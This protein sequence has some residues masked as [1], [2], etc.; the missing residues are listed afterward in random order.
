MCLT[1]TEYCGIIISINFKE[2]FMDI[3]RMIRKATSSIAFIGITA[4]LGLNLLLDVLY[5]IDFFGGHIEFAAFIPYMLGFVADVCLLV[6]AL[7][8]HGTKGIKLSAYAYFIIGIL[9]AIISVINQKM[10]SFKAG[11]VAVSA[12]VMVVMLVAIACIFFKIRGLPVLALGGIA[13]VSNVISVV[14]T[15]SQ[16]G[17]FFG[18]VPF[19]ALVI[20]IFT[21]PIACYLV[22][23][24]K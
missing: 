11:G 14:Q 5:V 12:I 2:Y 23:T 20:P 22:A 4:I 24:D 9:S 19:L 13:L 7:N 17:A 3:S 21:F 8:S 6:Y 1:D 15:I 16:I 10:F 18:L